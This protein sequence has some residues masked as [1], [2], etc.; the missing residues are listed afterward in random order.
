MGLVSSKPA[1]ISSD[2]LEVATKT[3]PVVLVGLA[4]VMTNRVATKL[5]PEYE[6]MSPKHSQKYVK[7]LTVYSPVVCKLNGVSR[8][9]EELS[10]VMAGQ[11]PRKS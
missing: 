9:K 6:G 4:E 7:A 1:A 5:L 3:T 11:Q 10:K 8:V 2:R